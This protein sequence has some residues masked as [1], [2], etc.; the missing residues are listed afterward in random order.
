MSA[1]R[2]RDVA[3]LIKYVLSEMETLAGLPPEE[4]CE[5][6]SFQDRRREVVRRIWTLVRQLQA[7]AAGVAP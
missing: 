2:E 4:A 7:D 6:Y 5:I 1:V 3:A